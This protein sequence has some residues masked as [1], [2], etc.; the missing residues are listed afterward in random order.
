MNELR[1]T[2]T[3]LWETCCSLPGILGVR[4]L[5]GLSS[6]RGGSA[7]SWGQTHCA[8]HSRMQAMPR[9]KPGLSPE[10]GSDPDQCSA[11]D[12]DRIQAVTKA[13]TTVHPNRPGR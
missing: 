2:L 3:G 8:R 10:P 4:L 11:L 9:P 1:D 6:G 13:Y 7:T 5:S 12:W